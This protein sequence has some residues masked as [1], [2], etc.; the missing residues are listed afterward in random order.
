MHSVQKQVVLF[1]LYILLLG[2]CNSYAFAQSKI[3]NEIEISI[4]K[5]DTTLYLGDWVIE[6]TI[7]IYSKSEFFD[8]T[9]WKFDALNGLLRIQAPLTNPVKIEF[10]SLPITFPKII[11][12]NSRVSLS[13]TNITDQKNRFTRESTMDLNFD[14]DLQQTGSLSRGIII[15]SN[16]DFALE[17]GLNFELSG[18]L[19][20]DLTL[21]AVLT[22]RS[23]PIQPDGTT[24]SIREF[25]KVLIRLQSDKTSLEMGDVDIALQQ[26]TFA[27]LNRRLQGAIG[28]YNSDKGTVNTA[29]STVRGTFLT[30][31][32]DGEDGVQGPYRLRGKN[33]EEFIIVLAGTE[34]VYINGNQVKRGENNEYIID[35]GVGEITFTDQIFIKDETRIYVE[36]E[37]ID[38][39]FNRTLIA[40]EAQDNFFDDRMKLGVTVIRQADG[41]DLLSQQALT[42]EEIQILR[43]VGDNLDQAIVSGVVSNSSDSENNVRYAQIDTTYNGETYS[44]FKNIPNSNNSNLVVRFSKVGLGTGSYERIGDTINGL[45]FN[46]VGPNN[47]SYEPFRQLPAP[48]KHQMIALNTQFSMTDNIFWSGEFSLSDFDKNRFSNKDNV[49]NTDMA[50]QAS[51][52]M[53]ELDIGFADVDIDIKRRQ[54]GKNF[55][56]FERTREV[57]F[58]RKWNINEFDTSGELLNEIQTKLNFS[59]RSNLSF[60]FGQLSIS[61]FESIRQHSELNLESTSKLGV[62]YAQEYIS[63]KNSVIDNSSEWFRQHGQIHWKIKDAFTPFV[64][65][66]H[67]DLRDRIGSI[68]LSTESQKFYEIGP[69]ISFTKNKLSVSA[70]YILRQEEGIIDGE[71]NKESIAREQRYHLDYNSNIGFNTQN[72]VHLRNKN[73]TEEFESTGRNDQNGFQIYSKMNLNRESFKTRF[74]YRTNTQRQAIRQEA[75]IE[76]GPELGQFVWI[77]ENENGIEE[78][79]EFF[80]ELSPNEGTYVLQFLPSDQLL[81]VINLNSQ[82]TLDWSPFQ[83]LEQVSGEKLWFHTIKFKSLIDLRELSTSSKEGDIYLLKLNTFRNDSTTLNGSI[84]VEQSLQVEPMQNLFLKLSFNASDRLNKRTIEIQKKKSNQLF[85]DLNYQLNK[86]LKLRLDTSMGTNILKSD[87]ISNRTYDIRFFSVNPGFTSRIS[88]S[89]QYGVHFGYNFKEDVQFERVHA[90]TSKLKTYLRAFMWQKVQSTANIELRDTKIT[91]V[92]NSFTNYELTEGTGTGTHLVWTLSAAYRINDLIR[93]NFNYDGRTVKDR[94]DI[95]TLKLVVSAIF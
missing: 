77:D 16:Q 12:L 37:Y 4:L 81:P 74:T 94:A 27:R 64:Q 50:M 68:E 2:F 44:I 13:D 11:R 48:Q 52:S 82:L 78:I 18:S 32:F 1:F 25:D 34:R 92:T 28:S 55:Q 66:E 59:D 41:D 91:G 72:R 46:W 24:Q 86:D 54:S 30:Q 67:E 39:D 20:D 45:L 65:F 53:K 10:S 90:K 35:Y 14:S 61:G 47:G 19:T 5:S 26:S 22:D 83:K 7:K 75:Y 76:V 17:S 40:A 51:V 70:A 43:Q 31:R 56:F 15:G 3:S 33:G 89:F 58:D 57:E 49:D 42:Q 85:L 60:G 84:R 6:S 63:A 88:R 23:I 8:S 36:Y 95:H 9:S 73:Y 80:P 38:Q 79:D 93:L 29:F 21:D 71:F 69:G 62:E 87:E